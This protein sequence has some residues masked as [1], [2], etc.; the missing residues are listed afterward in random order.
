MAAVVAACTAG[1]CRVESPCGRFKALAALV[2]LATLCCAMKTA[3]V[4]A[5]FAAACVGETLV[6][7]AVVGAVD[8]FAEFVLDWLLFVPADTAN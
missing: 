2:A 6:G 8:A 4:L 3:A 7:A 5:W 1:D